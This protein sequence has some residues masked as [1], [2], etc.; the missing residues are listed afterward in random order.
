MLLKEAA[1]T[2][3]KM[4]KEEVAM[5]VTVDDFSYYWQQANKHMSLS[6]SGLYFSQYKAASFD[7]YLVA[8]HAS[9]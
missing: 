5:Y 6:Y 4:T 7:W 2:Y 1:I 3:V 9:K 8:L